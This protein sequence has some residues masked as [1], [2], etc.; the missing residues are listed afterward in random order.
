ML[1]LA[2]VLSPLLTAAG[3][4]LAERIVLTPQLGAQSEDESIRQWQA[5]AARTEASAADFER[6]GW[7]FIAKARRTLDTGYYVLAEQT[8]DVLDAR[9][10]VTADARLLRGHVLH[11]LHQF[12][13]AEEVARELSQARG[14]SP[15]FAL[16]SDVLMEQGKLE[17][18]IAA[19]QQMVDLKPGPEA[20]S[21]VAHLRWLKGDLK[22]AI[23]AMELAARASSPRDHVN[24]AW[25]LTRLSG[26]YLQQGDLPRALRLAESAN[27]GVSDYAPG[28]FAAGRALL[29][30]EQPAAAVTALRQAAVLNPLPE[31]QWWLAD[32][33]RTT[34][35]RSDA[36]AVVAALERHGQAA[37]G[38][39]L[40]LFW[41]T[42]RTEPA[43]SVQLARDELAHRADVFTHDALA[44]ALATSGDLPAAHAAMRR[45]LAEGTRDARLFWHAGEIALGLGQTAEAAAFFEQAEPFAATLTPGERARLNAS[46][47][48]I[49]AA[50]ANAPVLFS[51]MKPPHHEN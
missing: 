34:G 30:L 16:L 43:R 49:P 41:A 36:A 39:T 6:L 1:S 17:P 45:A 21:R 48:S 23:E 42:R 47:R 38:R 3:S 44:W 25:V 12:Q 51:A 10:G 13:A 7:A 8:A 29:A 33:L 24:H 26:Y 15:D 32:A 27:H 14:L 50:V 31:Y 4:N 37:D 18:A 20:Y 11:N 19:L 2:V 9:H 40:A 46:V 35:E 22:G 5:R 28:L